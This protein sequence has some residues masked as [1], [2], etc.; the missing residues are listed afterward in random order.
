MGEGG[1]RK[2]DGVRRVR[3]GREISREM[4]RGDETRVVRRRA[5][6]AEGRGEGEWEARVEMTASN[7]GRVPPTPKSIERKG[8]RESMSSRTHPTNICP[9]DL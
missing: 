4:E 2:E 7:E 6:N 5:E 3:R 9:T 8:K 1:E